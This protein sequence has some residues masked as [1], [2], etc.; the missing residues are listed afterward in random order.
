MSHVGSA[1]KV[2]SYKKKTISQADW[3]SFVINAT[4][5]SER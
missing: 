3:E 1:L 5:I 2:S 4:L